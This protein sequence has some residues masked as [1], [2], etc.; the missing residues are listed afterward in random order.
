VSTVQTGWSG[1][2]GQVTLESSNGW[3]TNFNNLVVTGGNGGGGSTPTPTRTP[4]PAPPQTVT[5]DNLSPPNRPLNGQYPSGLINWGTNSWFLSG[6]YG[7]DPSNSVSFNGSGMT[8]AVLTFINPRRVVSLQAYNGGSSPSSV[9]LTC[10]G[11]SSQMTVGAGQNA[12]L[13]TGWNMACTTLTIASSNG[14]ETNFDAL[15]VQ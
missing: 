1:T 2:C 11:L 13:E 5:F 12:T 9:T 10:S 14:W 7:G 6:P 4:T 3:D 15:V 8:S